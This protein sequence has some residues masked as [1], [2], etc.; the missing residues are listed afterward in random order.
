MV[1][2]Q[3]REKLSTLLH[4]LETEDRKWLQQKLM[5]QDTASLLRDEKGLS[6]QELLAA[7]SWY[8]QQYA[9]S[10]SMRARRA[11]ARLWCIFMLLRYGGLRL[12]E[13]LALELGHM[14]W[15]AGIIHIQGEH[16][17]QVP[18]PA[19]PCLRLRQMMQDPA[20]FP[21]SGP[22]PHS[23]SPPPG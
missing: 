19:T 8:W 21:P 7:E 18:L 15:G 17:R 2:A 3:K 16:A 22:P 14:D 13:A 5:R 6:D 23:P 12:V 9:E 4:S 10:T 20:L 1:F 11:H